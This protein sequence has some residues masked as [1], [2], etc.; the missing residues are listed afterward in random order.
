MIS[1]RRSILAGLAVIATTPVARAQAQKQTSAELTAAPM[2]FAEIKAAPQF[3]MG[4]L[5]PA[6][7]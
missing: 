6:E 5:R 7:L 1:D 4:V 3:F 2:N